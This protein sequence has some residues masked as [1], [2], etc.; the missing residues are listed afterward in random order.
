MLLGDLRAADACPLQSRRFD[1]PPRAVPRRV[2][3]HA[4]ARSPPRGFAAPL[5]GGTLHLCRQLAW[6]RT[7][8]RE[9]GRYDDGQLTMDDGRSIVYRL[10]SIVVL[11]HAGPVAVSEPFDRPLLD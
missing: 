7:G 1:Q 11:E 2:L 6:V 8:Q 9:L 10:S 5:G 4:A 3:E